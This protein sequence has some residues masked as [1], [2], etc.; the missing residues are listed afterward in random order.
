VAMLSDPPCEEPDAEFFLEILTEAMKRGD[1]RLGPHH[2]PKCQS[3]SL[4]YFYL[5]GRRD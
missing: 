5:S 4:F 3:M 2:C 1:E